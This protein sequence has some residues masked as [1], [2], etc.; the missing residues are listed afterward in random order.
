MAGLTWREVGAPNFGA[1]LS[2]V[3]DASQA[4]GG[5]FNNLAANLAGIGQRQRRADTGAAQLALSRFGSNTDL[6]SAIQAGLVGDLQGQYSNLDSAALA[7]YLN[8]Y[9]TSLQNRE[10]T[11]QGIDRTNN[12]NQYG[13]QIADALVRAGQGDSTGWAAIQANPDIMGSLLTEAAPGV[14]T[15]QGQ[16]ATRA[17]TSRSNRANEGNAAARLALAQREFNAGNLARSLQERTL[18]KQLTNMDAAEAGGTSLNNIGDK[19]VAQF[20]QETI[21]RLQKEGKGSDYINSYVTGLDNAYKLRTTGNPNSAVADA[22]ITSSVAPV[23]QGNTQAANDSINATYD[24]R[25]TLMRTWR[26]AQDD[27]TDYKGD[28]NKAVDAISAIATDS[29]RNDIRDY[30]NKAVS[31]GV[32]LN[33]VVAAA[34][35]NLTS[36][37]FGSL[38]SVIPGLQDSSS[39]LDSS[40]ALDTARAL[41]N[42]N[43]RQELA[44]QSTQMNVD[45]QR[46]AQAEQGV[47]AATTLYQE[48]VT[49][50][51]SNSPQASA[52]WNTLQNSIN[53]QRNLASGFRDTA[54]QSLNSTGGTP[55]QTDLE[56][57][58]RYNELLRR[59]GNGSN[60]R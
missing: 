44:E 56:R 52:A 15:A 58:A 22:T 51:G 59:A 32:P 14:Q 45:R 53:S 10:Q 38:K 37:A 49:R 47:N 39:K 16:F 55:T 54:T 5:S 50:F 13:G 18:N 48:M 9:S 34:K 31:S 2:G 43:A 8:N 3:G 23:V 20:R 60:I 46:V 7:D 12:Q 24:S 33:Q 11:Q 28:S 4:I 26:N 21:E 25:N 30:V 42:S 6:Q 29:D 40:A 19:P 57:A 17:E 36:T 41:Q 35:N 27:A 1:A